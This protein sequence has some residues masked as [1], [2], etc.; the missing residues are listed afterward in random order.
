MENDGKEWKRMEKN[1]NWEIKAA[2]ASTRFPQQSCG[3]GQNVSKP[4]SSPY[5]KILGRKTRVWFQEGSLRQGFGPPE[6]HCLKPG[7]GQTLLDP[8]IPPPNETK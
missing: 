5:P 6:A 3:L 4:A 2:K 7:A 8:W 1:G